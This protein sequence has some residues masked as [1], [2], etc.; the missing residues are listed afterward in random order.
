M[1]EL[2]VSVGAEVF[3]V[4]IRLQPDATVS[5]DFTWL[6]GPADGT[7]G[8]TMGRGTTVSRDDLAAEA[9]LFVDAFYAPGGIGETDFPGHARA[10]RG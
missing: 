2:K 8:F 7:Y 10:A 3:L 1:H 5:Y 9:R 4:R 6:N